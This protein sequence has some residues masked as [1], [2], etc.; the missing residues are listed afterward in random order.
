MATV[1]TNPPASN[2]RLR[3]GVMYDF[4]L[5][6]QSTFDTPMLYADILG[7]LPLL[8]EW[9]Y[10]MVWLSEHHF[11]ADGYLPSFAPVAGA[12][13]AVTRRMRVST[14]VIL[15]PFHHPVRLAEDLGVLDNLSGGRI[16]I[17]IGLGYAPHEFAAFGRDRRHRVSLTEETL[18]ILRQ[19]ASPD[20][21]DID[22]KRYTIHGAD[23]YPKPVQPGG[24]PLWLAAQS[25]PGLKRAARYGAHLLPQGPRGMLDVWRDELRAVGKDPADQ[26]VGIARSWLVTDD[27]DRDL[28]PVKAAGVYR[29][30]M[31]KQWNAEAGENLDAWNAADKIPQTLIVGDEDHVYGELRDFAL[32]YG[33]T[34]LITSVIT[35]DLPSSQNESFQRFAEGVAPRLRA[36]V[37]S[38]RGLA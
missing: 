8:D 29:A 31:Y 20:P 11:V 37:D 23:V 6:P 34:D 26:R 9:G 35:T 19:A 36:A 15:A 12:I 27:P 14:D 21:V 30:K 16:E 38:A 1:P 2:H 3:I 32:E 4:R 22:G 17:G 5:A 28:P 7:Q 13:A 33:L 24:V 25:E 10:D 18:D